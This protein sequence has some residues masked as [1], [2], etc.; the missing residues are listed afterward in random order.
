MPGRAGPP[1]RLLG[2]ITVNAKRAV[3]LL[4]KP[5]GL[6]GRPTTEAT[7]D[8]VGGR[9]LPRELPVGCGGHRSRVAARGEG[10]TAQSYPERNRTMTTPPASAPYQRPRIFPLTAVC[11][12]PDTSRQPT[13]E[14]LA[15]AMPAVA[16]GGRTGS[17][18]VAAWP[19][20]GLA[21]GR[22]GQTYSL[23]GRG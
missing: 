21:A 14:W 18:R 17:R 3:E 23:E 8:Q 5:T 7:P 22:Q 9:T 1:T 19:P 20:G 11:G 12:T 16:R 10:S 2:A 13:Q 4:A 15:R 6:S